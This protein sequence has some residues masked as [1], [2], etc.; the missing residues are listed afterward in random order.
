[1]IPVEFA[2]LGMVGTLIA[3]MLICYGWITR[4]REE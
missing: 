4:S 3:G 2:A 1:M